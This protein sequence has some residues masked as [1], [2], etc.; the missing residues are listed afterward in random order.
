MATAG[1]TA[2]T[3]RLSPPSPAGSKT[4]AKVPKSMINGTKGM[5]TPSTAGPK[6]VQTRT[7]FVL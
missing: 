4:M 7:Q 1:T 6:V 5:A 3:T 2:S